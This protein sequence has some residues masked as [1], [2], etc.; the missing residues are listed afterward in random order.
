MT[1]NDYKNFL[2]FITGGLMTLVFL[3]ALIQVA[4]SIIKSIF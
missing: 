1:T 2:Q 4:I 3:Q